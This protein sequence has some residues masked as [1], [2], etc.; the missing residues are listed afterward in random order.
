MR[1]ST[2]NFEPADSNSALPALVSRVHSVKCD[3]PGNSPWAWRRVCVAAGAFPVNLSGFRR[4]QATPVVRED[5]RLWAKVVEKRDG[6]QPDFGDFGVTYPRMPPKSRGTPDPNVRY[7]T[8]ENW[9]VFVYPRVRQGNDDFLTLSQDL[10]NSPHWPVTELPRPGAT[11]AFRSAPNACV[12]RREEA[13]SVFRVAIDGV[14]E[15]ACA[16]HEAS[17]P[18]REVFDVSTHQHRCLVGFLS[19]RT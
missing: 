19:C 5:A 18:L 16:T 17:V 13:L 3:E 11:S 2:L 1:R 14:T 15:P 12:R 9:Q 4:G 7:T 8:E 6:P 10:V